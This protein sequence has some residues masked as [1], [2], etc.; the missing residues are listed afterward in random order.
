MTQ[1]MREIFI[2]SD[3]CIT[4]TYGDVKKIRDG[5]EELKFKP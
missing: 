4:A 5:I 3:A 2:L 1:K